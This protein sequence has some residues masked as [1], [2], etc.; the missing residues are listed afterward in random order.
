MD[1]REH[2]S[3]HQSGTH[4]DPALGHWGVAGLL[5]CPWPGAGQLHGLWAEADRVLE[6]LLQRHDLPLEAQI[7][8]LGAHVSHP[9]PPDDEAG[10]FHG[11]CCGGAAGQGQALAQLSQSLTSLA[12]SR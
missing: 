1:P 9:G 6:R 8:A 2:S 5:I 4:G 11:H 7:S 12:R 10:L 3:V